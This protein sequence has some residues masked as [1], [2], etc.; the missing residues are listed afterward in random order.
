MIVLSLASYTLFILFILIGIYSYRKAPGKYLT[1]VFFL[2]CVFLAWWALCSSFIYMPSLN[3][4][5][6]KTWFILSIAPYMVMP[7][8]V[9][10]FILILTAQKKLLDKR[11]PM[12]LFYLPALV[13][14]SLGFLYKHAFIEFQNGTEGW[15]SHFHLDNILFILYI[16]Y[17]A[18]YQILSL[19]I[20]LKWR[21]TSHSHKL[22]LQSRV[23][24]LSIIISQILALSLDI[25]LPALGVLP[26]LHLGHIIWG[27]EIGGIWLAI[28]RYHLL[29][30]PAF[31]NG[32]FIASRISEMLMVLDEKGKIILSNN[33]LHEILGFD[34][35]T[36][37]GEKISMVIS[38]KTIIP[39][40]M[41][42]LIGPNPTPDFECSFLSRDGEEI[43]VLVSASR[44]KD[45]FGDLVGFTFIAK[46]LRFQKEMESE[47]DERK[48][49][50][51]EVR[52]AHHELK[53]KHKEL[54]GEQNKLKIRNEM[55][56][57][58]LGMARK[59]QTELIPS[60]S[61]LPGKLAFF[62][63]PMEKVG[64]DFYDFIEFPNKKQIGIFLSD[65]SG[66]GVPAAFITSMIKS[67]N[68]QHGKNFEKPADFLHSLNDFLLNKT[69]ENFIT[70]FYGIFD[71]E[72]GDFFYS[73]AGHDSP[74]LIKKSQ[75]LPLPT[76]GRGIPLGILTRQELAHMS[77]PYTNHHVH[78]AKKNKLFMYTDGLTETSNI[79][80]EDRTFESQDFMS[81]MQDLKDMKSQTFVQKMFEKLSDFRQSKSFEDDICMICLE[82]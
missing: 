61:P 60:E 18:G 20:L 56:E 25:L 53:L 7:S 46:D 24:I 9:L 43:P 8:L 73:N 36:L 59:I 29:Q 79:Y 69:G 63:K 57:I 62:Y 34:E 23:L 81:A 13:F 72:T 26:Y 48:R 35:S 80:D 47:I 74:Y 10:H 12:L 55:M 14:I 66:H 31:I 37:Y 71:T 44:H 58:E 68:L 33:K 27:L 5:Q 70:A 22:A 11:W 54:E 30:S 82:A 38:D 51:V 78:L 2:S 77:K 52:Y 45:T 4:V 49:W 76:E 6:L 40:L 64:G 15:K 65:V 75:I 3:N 17:A 39:R 16:I 42:K 32:D 28:H 1:H 41:E 19:L 50:E 67:H 21:K